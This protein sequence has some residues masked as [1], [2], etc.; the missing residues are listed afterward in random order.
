M[1]R[2]VSKFEFEVDEMFAHLFFR[3]Y[4]STYFYRCFNSENYFSR[5]IQ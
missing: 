2:S 3:K 1:I 5:K 4:V